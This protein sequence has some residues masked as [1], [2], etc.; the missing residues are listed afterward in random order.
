MLLFSPIVIPLAKCLDIFLGT[1]G[2]AERFEK[3]DLVTFIQMHQ[4][5]KLDITEVTLL[6][7]IASLKNLTCKQVS[8]KASKVFMLSDNDIID[9]KMIDRIVKKNFSKV[10]IYSETNRNK[11]VGIL[12]SKS[13]IPFAS[14]FMS[15]TIKESGIKLHSPPL[16]V[17]LDTPLLGVLYL[18]KKQKITTALIRE[19][20]ENEHTQMN[21][22]TVNIIAFL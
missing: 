1:H 7:S 21:G 5:S 9:Q 16:I 14:K 6:T 8:V 10:P 18:F 19:N 4:G 11:I 13:M 15:K 20:F 12:P 2:E 17:P 22:P 3:E